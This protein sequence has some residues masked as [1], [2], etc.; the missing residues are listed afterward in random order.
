MQ[1]TPSVQDVRGGAGGRGCALISETDS[2]ICPGISAWTLADASSVKASSICRRMA[3]MGMRSERATNILC[4]DKYRRHIVIFV[5][6]MKFEVC[7]TLQLL[8]SRC[9]GGG[10]ARSLCPSVSLLSAWLVP[11]R[12]SPLRRGYRKGRTLAVR[13]IQQAP[14]QR[15]QS[16]TRRAQSR[17][18]PQSEMLRHFMVA[19]A[20]QHFPA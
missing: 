10:M 17:Q 6:Q 15:W 1:A 5:C 3:T 8:Q 18:T 7:G 12:L 16:A 4:V 11:S 20:N 13:D 9:R 14:D 2:G 19:P